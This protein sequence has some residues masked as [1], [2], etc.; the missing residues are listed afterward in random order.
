MSADDAA[1]PEPERNLGPFDA[2]MLVMGGIVGVGIFFTPGTVAGL[3]PDESTFLLAWILGGLVALCGAFTFAE[4]GACMPRAGGWFVYL[5]EAFGPLPA[6]LFAWTILGVVS[7]GA[8]AVIAAFCATALNGLVPGVG[9]VG[10]VSHLA[11]GLAIVIGLTTMALM[12]IRLGATVH[13]VVMV[14]KLVA[15][16]ALG[17]AGV[18][19]GF[20]L[21]GQGSEAA[22]PVDSVPA[23]PVGLAAIALG[24]VGAALPV[25]FSYGGWQNLCYAADRVRDPRRVL[26]RAILGGVVGAVA[27]YLVVNLG[28]LR[29]FGLEGLGS[30]GDFAAALAERVMGEGGRGALQAAMAVSA[31]GVCAVTVLL[32]PGI[33]VAMARAG[34]FFRAYGKLHARTAAPVLALVTQ[35]AVACGYLLWSEQ[36]AWLGPPAEGAMDLDTLTGSV[37]FAEWIFHALAA[38]ALLRLRRVHPDFV[39]LGSSWARLAPFGYL[40]A[41]IAVVAG[42]LFATPGLRVVVGLVAVGLGG[43]V[44]LAWRPFR[45][46]SA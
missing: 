20:G 33:Y 12:G 43:L 7:T 2:T 35:G 9:A 22:L 46:A 1:E 32:T 19:V 6:F 26:P 5:R 45:P 21:G 44:Y 4:L 11:V 41:A 34:L 14:A 8:I 39:G 28:F 27:L 36:E 15:I 3:V 10:S 25:F 13:G 30:R 29:A 42:N 37:V 38:A 18:A 16:A 24:L 17:A 23:E 40:L 31:L